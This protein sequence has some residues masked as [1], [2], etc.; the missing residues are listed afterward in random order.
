MHSG[1]TFWTEGGRGVGMGHVVRSVTV[2]RI[3]AGLGIDLSFIVN[4]DPAVIALLDRTPFEYSIGGFDALEQ[5]DETGAVVVF[6]TKKDFSDLA[7]T[8]LGSQRRVVTIDNLRVNANSSSVIIPSA[9]FNAA[10]RAGAGG[11]LPAGGAERLYGGSDYV[12][13]GE[14][15]LLLRDVKNKTVKK[16]TG[17]TEKKSPERALRVLITMGGTDPNGLGEVIVNALQGLDAVEAAVVVGPA[18]VPSETFAELIE[19]PPDGISFFTDVEDLAPYAVSS[20]VAFT[21]MGITVYELAAIGVPSILIGNYR[22]DVEEMARLES[23]G[24]GRSLG[25]HGDVTRSDIRNIIEFFIQERKSLMEIGE[26]AR[27]TVDGRGAERVAAI[28]TGLLT[29]ADKDVKNGARHA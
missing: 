4:D 18:T 3:L 23:L 12:I 20:D 16:R 13:V 22:D 1:V 25:Y 7:A 19:S 14:N 29:E 17:D 9:T 10:D 27:A 15:F 8:L 11:E 5:I 2:A 6:D 26:S 21:A 28:V 24:I